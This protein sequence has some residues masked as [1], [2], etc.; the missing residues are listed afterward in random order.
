MRKR[1]VKTAKGAE[2]VA[3]IAVSFSIVGIDNQRPLVMRY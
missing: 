3:E 1:F 2:R